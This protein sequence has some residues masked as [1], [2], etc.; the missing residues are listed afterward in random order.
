MNAW[1]KLKL[2][3][4]SFVEDIQNQNSLTTNRAYY[5]VKGYVPVMAG[6]VGATARAGAP[7]TVQQTVILSNGKLVT[8]SSGQVTAQKVSSDAQVAAQDASLAVL[9]PVAGVV[10]AVVVVALILK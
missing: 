9:G 3:G 2:W 10:L 8:G 7:Q 6:D 5:A 4:S 1:E